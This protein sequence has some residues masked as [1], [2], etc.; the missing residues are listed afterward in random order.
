MKKVY[1]DVCMSRTR[2]YNWLSRFK[3][4]RKDFNDAQRPGYSEDSNRGELVDTVRKIIGI[5]ANLSAKM[6][7]VCFLFNMS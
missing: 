1:G 4:D 7:V 6:L 3:K 5:D 2:F